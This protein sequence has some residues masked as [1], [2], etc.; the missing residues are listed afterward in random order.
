MLPLPA[1]AASMVD[2]EDGL[3]MS[4]CQGILQEHHGHISREPRQDGAMLLRVE[5]PATE[6]APAA[7]KQAKNSTVPVLWRGGSSTAAFSFR[8]EGDRRVMVVDALGDR[9]GRVGKHR[10]DAVGDRQRAILFGLS[11]RFHPVRIR[12]ERRP[13]LGRG[14]TALVRQDV[15]EGVV[16][17]RRV[18]GDVADA[19]PQGSRDA[20]GLAA[21]SPGLLFTAIPAMELTP[22][23]TSWGGPRC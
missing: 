17:E 14:L 9:L 12:A 7:A 18:L 2:A 10:D 19:A 1:R 4:A 11:F 20:A 23:F 6:S 8:Y 3:G 15:D 21:G 22:D 16:L 5:L 13:A